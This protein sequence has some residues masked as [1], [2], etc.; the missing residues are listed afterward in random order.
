MISS[1]FDNSYYR[2]VL[3]ND[4]FFVSGSKTWNTKETIK[5]D[6]ILDHQDYDIAITDVPSVS[7]NEIKEALQ[8]EAKKIFANYKDELLFDFYNQP[9]NH[10]SSKKLVNIVAVE[11]LYIDKI[12]NKSSSKNIKI[13]KITIP[14]MV[15]KNHAREISISGKSCFILVNKN[16]GKVIIIEND[17]ICFSR[18]FNL[19]YQ[20]DR[21]SMPYEELLLL[22]V[23]RSL[24]YY[25][26]QYRLSMPKDFFIL[27][28]LITDKVIAALK[29]SISN[30]LVTDLKYTG[31]FNN[32]ECFYSDCQFLLATSV[33]REG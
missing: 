14:E 21:H 32:D 3:F 8:W 5:C 33:V 28:D 6:F 20:K 12:I 9:S 13:N 15:Y 4:R 29:E 30:N 18:K 16:I 11:K 23:Q 7:D 27:G 1:I 31:N 24:D 22:E 2:C 10:H 26:R 25:E 19:L 17:I